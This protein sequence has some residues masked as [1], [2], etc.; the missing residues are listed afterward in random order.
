VATAVA[1]DGERLVVLEE[2]GSPIDDQ[3]VVREYQHGGFNGP[4]PDVNTDCAR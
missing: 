4:R 1:V 2:T 3:A